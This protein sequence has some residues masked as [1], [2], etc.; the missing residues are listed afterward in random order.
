MNDELLTILRLCLLGLCYLFFFR[1]LRA[2]WV[3]TR[4]DKKNTSKTESWISDYKLQTMSQVER[5][6][7]EK[8]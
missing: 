5:E 8:N 2:V 1:V 4:E 7:Y 6:N 3:E